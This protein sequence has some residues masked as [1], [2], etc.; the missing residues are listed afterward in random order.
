MDPSDLRQKR[1]DLINGFAS[2]IFEKGMGMEKD[3][4]VL[5]SKLREQGDHNLAKSYEVEFEKLRR[6]SSR[7]G[8]NWAS[9]IMLTIRD[10][11][12]DIFDK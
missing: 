3:L 4:H 2:S 7:F 10:I 8:A 5:C 12:G 1:S 6:T 9:D 11:E